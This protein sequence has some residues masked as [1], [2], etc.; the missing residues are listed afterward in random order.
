MLDMFQMYDQF[1]KIDGF[2]KLDRSQKSD[3]HF[4]R[5]YNFPLVR[6]FVTETL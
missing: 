2:Q 6:S 5:Y 4:L 3:I 1:Q